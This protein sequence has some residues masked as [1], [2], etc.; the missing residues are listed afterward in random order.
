VAELSVLLID[1]SDTDRYILKRL[2]AKTEL[3][4][5]VIEKSSGHEAIAYLADCVIDD[6][7]KELIFHELNMPIMSG[8][9]FLDAF[10]MLL[11]HRPEL[12][13]CT[14]SIMTSSNSPEDMRRATIYPF[15]ASHIV[16][17]PKT[18]V[19]QR[20]LSDCAQR[21]TIGRRSTV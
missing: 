21:G 15:V 7:S 14:V 2:L 16:K 3:A 8:F 13:A 20:M 19:L 1:D 12:A 5:E 10:A 4:T 11:V 9:E 17:M 6:R 18:D